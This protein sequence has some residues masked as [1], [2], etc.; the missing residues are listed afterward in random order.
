MNLMD[1]N[2]MTKADAMVLRNRSKGIEHSLVIVISAIILLVITLAIVSVSTKSIGMIGKK[3][4]EV[5]E[6]VNSGDIACSGYVFE[7]DC[8]RAKN[9][10]WVQGKCV[11]KK[12]EG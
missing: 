6:E 9:C 7:D 12:R 8:N 4:K 11:N 10:M 3:S 1:V 2:G 5:G